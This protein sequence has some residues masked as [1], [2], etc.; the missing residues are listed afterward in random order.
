MNDDFVLFFRREE[1]G[2]TKATTINYLKNIRL[3]FSYIIR[4]YVYE[5]PNF[6]AGFDQSPCTETITKIK[7]LDQ[8]LD[9]VYK[10]TTKQ[11]PQE[12]FRRK[13]KEAKSMPDYTEVVKCL[14]DIS[15]GIEDNLSGLERAFKEAV[16]PMVIRSEKKSDPGQKRV[17]VLVFYSRFIIC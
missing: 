15:S 16:G 13:T 4:A 3:L 2:Q 8:K 14:G 6:P 7:L 11:Q 12:L 1:L 9:L 17:S 5:D 10:R